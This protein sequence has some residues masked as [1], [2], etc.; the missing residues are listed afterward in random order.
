MASENRAWGYTR[1]QGAL[2]NLHHQVARGTIANI[3]KQ[4]GLEPAPER[5][6]RTTWQ[7][8]LQTHWGVLAAADFFTVE[9]WTAT[10]LTRFAVLFV[11]DLA[12]RRVEIAGI[13]SEPDGAWVTECGRQITD[14]IE[15][16][17]RGKSLL[18]HDRGQAVQ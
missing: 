5:Q 12:T 14:P 9:V 2:A 10:G 16:C 15:G 8:F 3:F 11:I 1:I 6:K 7:E 17:L 4:H 18:R 13:G